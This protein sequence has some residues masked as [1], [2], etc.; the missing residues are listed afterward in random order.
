MDQ[1]YEHFHKNNFR[2]LHPMRSLIITP[3]HYSAVQYSVSGENLASCCYFAIN[4][5]NGAQV[6]KNCAPKKLSAIRYILHTALFLNRLCC[7][8]LIQFG[9]YSCMH[10]INC[11]KH[12]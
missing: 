5:C 4:S 12:H 3:P 10:A 2:S 9:P 11:I 6:C 8:K 1:P 7:M